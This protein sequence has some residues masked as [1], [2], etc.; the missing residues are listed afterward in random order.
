MNFVLI[1]C[2]STVSRLLYAHSHYNMCAGGGYM[3]QIMA[4]LRAR[5]L[6]QSRRKDIPTRTGSLKAA[7][8]SDPRQPFDG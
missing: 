3:Y 7:A 5:P 1:F 8:G 4:T 6:K 2:N